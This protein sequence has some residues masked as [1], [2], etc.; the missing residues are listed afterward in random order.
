MVPTRC[1]QRPH[2]NRNTQAHTRIF[3]LH[4]LS[5]SL[6]DCP[7]CSRT[8]VEEIPIRRST[9]P[10]LCNYRV[11]NPPPPLLPPPVYRSSCGP[12]SSQCR[13]RTVSDRFIQL[14]A[15]THI[16]PSPLC[17][18]PE[19]EKIWLVDGFYRIHPRSIAHRVLGGAVVVSGGCGVCTSINRFKGSD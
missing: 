16:H 17:S 8:T 2:T 13:T 18:V 4:F 7:V 6:V 19:A 3:F 9:L 12:G 5:G 11:R 14:R 15:Y 10:W 1:L